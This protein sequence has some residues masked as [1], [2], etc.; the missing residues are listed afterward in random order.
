MSWPESWLRL[1]DR[2]LASARFQSW[3]AGHPLASRAARRNASR[4]FDLCAGFVYSQ[5]LLASVE[6]GLLEILRSG[7]RTTVALSERLG[8]AP[9]RA[10]RLIDAAV[11]LNLLQPR[12]RGR[13][14]LGAL[15]AML[16]GN[17]AVLAMIRHHRLLYSDLADPVALLRDLP[18]GTALGDYWAYARNGDP[19]QLGAQHT[20][21]YSELMA[22]TQPLIAAQVLDAYPL[23]RHRSLLDIGGGLGEFALAAARRT[24]RLQCRVFDLP[25]MAAGAQARFE[26]AGFGDR[27][28][29]I[30]GN[31]LSDPLP[32]GADVISLVRV[33][34]DHDDP[35]VRQLLRAVRAALAPGGTLLIAEP[36]IDR[37]TQRVGEAYFGFYLLAMGQGHAR[38]PAQLASLLA[39]TGFPTWRR[40]PTRIPLQCQVILTQPTVNHA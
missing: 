37:A 31:F 3:A 27:I 38:T 26:A 40:Q 15:G 7:P 20:G 34:H 10:Q 39:E 32:G 12:G 14:G 23:H 36:M 25:A 29:A 21:G 1:R 17:P 16:L 8:L 13:V 24:P 6:L 2:C 9:D 33:L 28:Q 11:A 35:A 5:I 18:T 30:G 4:L 22:A 19:A